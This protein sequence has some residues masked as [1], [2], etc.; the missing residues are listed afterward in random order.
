MPNKSSDDIRPRREVLIR[1]QLIR[2][3]QASYRNM[4]QAKELD[5]MDV[6]F[7]RDR[8]PEVARM[9]LSYFLESIPGIGR[10][11]CKC[12]MKELEVTEDTDTKRLG[13]L[14]Y[15]QLVR[16]MEKLPRH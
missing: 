16:L 10:I 4:L 1:G 5:P 2:Q 9:R 6:V 3:K 7:R 8:E 15:R 13:D 12:I 14:E 11:K